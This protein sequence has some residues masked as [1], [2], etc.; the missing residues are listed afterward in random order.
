MTPSTLTERRSFYESEFEVR[1]VCTWL[2]GRRGVKFALIPGRHTGIVSPSHIEDKDN[3]VIIDEWRS[4]AD[5]RDYALEYLPEGLYY[6]RNRYLDIGECFKCGNKRGLCFG[7]YN[8]DGQQLAFDLDPENVDCPYHGHI[9]EKMSRGRGL[10]FCMYEFKEVRRQASELSRLMRE[11][12]RRVDVV[13]SGRGFH[14]VVE[15]EAAYALSRKD[16]ATLARKYGRRFA[17]D[18]WVTSGSSRLLRLPNSL[19]GIV[20]RKCMKIKLERDL[21]RFDPRDSSL[22]VPLFRRSA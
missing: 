14:V 11:K 3:V 13:F 7:C 20:S 4:V 1:A 22:V 16:R 5:V 2:R 12:F 19:N 8:F 18:E 10:L 17:I 15:D 21:M 9:G 6:D